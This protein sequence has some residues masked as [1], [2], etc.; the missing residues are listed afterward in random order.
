[1]ARR[2]FATT[3]NSDL[4]GGADFNRELEYTIT[5][6]ATALSVTINNA[7]T[8]TSRCYTDPLHPGTKGSVTGDYTVSIF[9]STLNA[10]I[11]A[12]VTLH[13]INSTGTI[14]TSSSA[15]SSVLFDTT[16]AK[17]FTFTGLSLG[18]FTS[19]DRLRV[20][21]N[22]A[23]SSAHTN[24]SFGVRFNDPDTYVLTPFAVRAFH[25]T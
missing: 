15:S 21:F 2:Y 1:M 24:Q 8:E 6:A 12:T 7:S 10:S 4:T 18:T 19:T 23:N 25:T 14:Q 22:F 13:R 20:D 11:S 3:N 17:V 9:C 5:G 16:G